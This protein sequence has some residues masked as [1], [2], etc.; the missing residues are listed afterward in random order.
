WTFGTLAVRQQSADLLA[1]APKVKDAPGGLAAEVERAR[2]ATDA[3]AAW[4]AEQ[5]PSRTGPSGIG[6]ANYDWYLQNVQ[7]APYTWRDE[8]AIMER[9]LARAHALLA[10]EEQRNAGLPVQVP[11]AS[12]EEHARRFDAGVTCYMKFLR[13]RDILTVHEDME[14][15]LRA[16]LGP[17]A[18]GPR[19]FFTEV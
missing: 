14:S 19:E 3:F 9:E 8:V 2:E 16:A 7:L 4:L 6:V 1:L 10:L 13:D 15:A 11:L 18:P 17:F 5:A 12:A